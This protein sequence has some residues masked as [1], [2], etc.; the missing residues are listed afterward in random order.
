MDDLQPVELNGSTVAGPRPI[1]RSWIIAFLIVALITAA[2]ALNGGFGRRRLVTDL[3]GPQLIDI[4]PATV[5][6]DHAT[7]QVLE[8][9]STAKYFEIKLF[10]TCQV[11]IDESFNSGFAIAEA[12][13]LPYL[14]KVY[15]AQDPLAEF[16]WQGTDGRTHLPPGMPPLDCTFRF[17]VPID[18]VET[19]SGDTLKVGFS[20]LVYG[21]R[22]AVKFGEMSW[23]PDNTR[24]MVIEIPWLP[25]GI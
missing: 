1:P 15:V 17:S 9:D 8:P 4:G 25:D 5:H 7:Y 6:L 12:I 16:S 14:D 20:R 11:T 22:Y 13:M 19:H 23:Y 3:G 10:G 18:S 24:F 21:D 2:V